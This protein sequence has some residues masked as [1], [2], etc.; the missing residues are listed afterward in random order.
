MRPSPYLLS[1]CTLLRGLP[2]EVLRAVAES[3]E[4][5]EVEKGRELFREGEPST[6]F[7]LVLA[8]RVSLRRF[9]GAGHEQVLGVFGEGDSFAEA[10]LTRLD[11]YPASA[12]ALE[13]CRLAH[14]VKPPF[15]QCM[16]EWPELAL[17]VQAAMGDH[18]K[19]MVELLEDQQFRPAEARVARHLLREGAAAGGE[20]WHL[21]T[22]KKVLAAALGMTG[23][24]LS[25]T[26]AQFRDEGLLQVRGRE[27]TLLDAA[28]LRRY[29]GD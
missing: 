2:A 3:C 1:R 27:I 13:T 11:R 15:L 24:T 9:T 16:R 7:F 20:R 4:I 18:L 21:A 12:L 5:R 17:R 28:G 22:T 19:R 6:G 8:G 26:L 29:A 25:R 14:A 23:E 10:T